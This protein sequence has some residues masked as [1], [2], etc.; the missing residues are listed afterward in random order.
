MQHYVTSF[1][2]FD[3][4]ISSNN[5]RDISGKMGCDSQK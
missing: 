5:F 3:A 1:G 4:T 2:G